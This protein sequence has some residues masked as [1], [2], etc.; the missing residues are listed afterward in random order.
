MAKYDIITKSG[1]KV[2]TANTLPLAKKKASALSKKNSKYYNIRNN[3]RGKYVGEVG[4][5]FYRTS[6]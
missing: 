4:V 6:K 5:K 3:E 1:R 2:G